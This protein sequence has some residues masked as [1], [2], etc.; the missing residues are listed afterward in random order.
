MGANV[1]SRQG[2]VPAASADPPHKLTTSSPS[3]QIAVAAPTS[4]RS[5]KFL[6]KAARTFLKR[7]AHDP[8]MLTLTGFS[9]LSN[10]LLGN[11]LRKGGGAQICRLHRPDISGN[12]IT[13]DRIIRKRDRQRR[14]CLESIHPHAHL[15]GQSTVAVDACIQVFPLRTQ[16]NIA[17]ID[18]RNHWNV[19]FGI[20]EPKLEWR[21]LQHAVEGHVAQV[22][23][24][25]EGVLC[26]PGNITE[27]HAA[28]RNRNRNKGGEPTRRHILSRGAPRIVRSDSV[29]GFNRKSTRLNSSHLVISYA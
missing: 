20:P 16:W 25:I 17:H 27:W 9:S 4:L 12:G 14:L 7:D 8:S 21:K 5:E 23:G 29:E 15:I 10:R 1:F 3:T 24:R 19:A 13:G 28:D 11:G 18:V 6:S 2:V 22:F 26:G